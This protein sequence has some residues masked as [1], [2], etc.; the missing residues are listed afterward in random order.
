[1][2]VR[3]MHKRV[4]QSEREILECLRERERVIREHFTPPQP[5]VQ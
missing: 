5:V 3:E 1:L 2:R 4:I